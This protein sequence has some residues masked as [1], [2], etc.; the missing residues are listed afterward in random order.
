M[1]SVRCADAVV[2]WAPAKVNL[3]LEVLAKRADGYHEINTLMVPVGLH[4]TL[5]FKE[6]ASGDVRLHCDDPDLSTGPDNLIR[7]AADLLR[8]R[9]GVGRGARIALAKRIPMAAGLAGGSSDAA[10]TLAGLNRLWELGLADADLAALGAELGSDVPF[11]FA[12]SAAGCTGRGEHVTPVH[13]GRRLTFVLACPGVG[14][15]TAEVYRNVTV[16]DT[17]AG[18]EAIRAAVAAGDPDAIGRCLHNRLQAPAERLCPE[19]AR[20]RE[21]LT[22]L[23]PAGLLMSGSGTSVFALC[24]DH[25]EALRVA[26]G[27]ESGRKVGDRPDPGTG[28]GWRLFMVRSC[29]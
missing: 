7:R 2:V 16:P 11:F 29:V 8:Q 12:N 5:E 21:R 6:E 1:L 3:F 14:L 22:G 13:L 4:D 24:R 17:P 20:L 27:L 28:K 15:S 25:A 9:H 10:A 19:V 26:R 23:N 18:G